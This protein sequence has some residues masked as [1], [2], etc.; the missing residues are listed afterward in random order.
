MV[1]PKDKNDDC[2]SLILKTLTDTDFANQYS[3]NEEINIA[4][5]KYD[6]V[7]KKLLPN[8]D[9]LD[10]NGLK[11]LVFSLEG[12]DR[13]GDALKILEEHPAAQEDTD[14]MGIIGGRYKRS[15][16]KFPSQADAEAAFVYY[17]LA[18]EKSTAKKN[19]DQ[20]YYHAIN[21]AFLSLV[22]EN[23]KGRMRTYAQQA[24]DATEKC[25]EDSWKYG[26]VAEASMYLGDMDKAKEYYTKAAEMSG[27]RE[28]ISMHLNA[29]AG[30]TT[31]KQTDNLKDEFI[32]FLKEHFLK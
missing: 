27:I 5:G 11:R 19:Y 20:I 13:R 21:L 25:E 29:Y 23:D 10:K 4:L 24:L 7:V 14:L 30:Y 26:T 18:L 28:K 32:V 16:L 9:A 15:Y 2:Y 6:A 3:N 22:A 1:K 12:L 17:E 31:L 8:V